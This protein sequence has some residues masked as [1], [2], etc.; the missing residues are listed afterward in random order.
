M[1]RVLKTKRWTEPDAIGCCRE[2][3]G[4]FPAKVETYNSQEGS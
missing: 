2:L 3:H 4:G 1:F